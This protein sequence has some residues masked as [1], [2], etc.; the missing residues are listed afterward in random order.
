MKFNNTVAYCKGFYKARKGSVAEMWKDMAHCIN[1]DGWNVYSRRDVAIWCMNRI[2]DFAKEFPKDAWQVSFGMFYSKME[3]NKEIAKIAKPYT[4]LSRELDDMD[5]II[6]TYRDFV[7][8]IDGDK[9]SEGVI[10]NDAVLPID[11]EN[12]SDTL[13]NNII[14]EY[15]T[16]DTNSWIF[17]TYEDIERKLY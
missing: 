12:I 4:S 11:K 10:P 7:R 6:W 8:Y 3:H 17:Q 14:N 16:Q 9:F 1:C 2:E 5:Y 15:Q 13:W